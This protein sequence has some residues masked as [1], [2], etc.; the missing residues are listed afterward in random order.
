MKPTLIVSYKN[1][2]WVDC[3]HILYIQQ[4]KKPLHKDKNVM[5]A[6]GQDNVL[7][8]SRPWAVYHVQS[9]LAV[10][11]ERHVAWRWLYRGK[12][13]PGV[14][15]WICQTHAHMFKCTVDPADLI[16][17]CFGQQVTHELHP[18]AHTRERPTEW[19]RGQVRLVAVRVI[20]T[21]ASVMLS[22]KAKRTAARHNSQQAQSTT[23]VQ[24]SSSSED[25]R[26]VR[27]DWGRGKQDGKDKDTTKWEVKYTTLIIV[28][29]IALST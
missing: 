28:L 19:W 8:N 23:A 11:C 5:H 2:I 12:E 9:Q 17:T 21:S 7:A 27:R 6:R 29:L 13:H 24:S 20:F 25:N 22:I 3:I 10:S 14:R 18:H 1:K 26:D 4:S 16:C 15:N